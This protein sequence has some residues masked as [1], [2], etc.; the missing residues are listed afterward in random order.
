M[1]YVSPRAICSLPLLRSAVAASALNGPFVSAPS[2][3]APVVLGD[4]TYWRASA[5]LK[6]AADP[7]LSPE[8]P[9]SISMSELMPA[10]N[11]KSGSGVTASRTGTLVAGNP[12]RLACD[13]GLPDARTRCDPVRELDHAAQVEAQVERLEHAG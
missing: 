2:D 11:G 5:K 9:V 1:E 6:E 3:P 10:R 7:S 8:W 12:R 13:Q 4:V